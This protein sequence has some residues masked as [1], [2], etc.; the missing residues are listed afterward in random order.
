MTAVHAHPC[1]CK[2]YSFP[3]RSGSG[4]C[5]AD[6]DGPFCGTCGEPCSPV[7]FDFGIGSYEFWGQTGVDTNIQTV[8]DCCEA[9]LFADAALTKDYDHD[10][11]F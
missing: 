11:S 4:K 9:P 8:S 3:H 7:D 2:A 5:H 1:T 6:D 10:D